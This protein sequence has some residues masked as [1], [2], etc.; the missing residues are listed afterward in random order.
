MGYQDKNN[1]IRLLDMENFLKYLCGY[2]NWTL[3][4]PL[5]LWLQQP[6]LQWNIGCDW[7]IKPDTTLLYHHKDRITWVQRHRRTYSHY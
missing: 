1:N 5:G 2:N 3:N 4:E 6:E 7:F